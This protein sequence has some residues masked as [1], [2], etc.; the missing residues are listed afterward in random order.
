MLWLMAVPKSPYC[1]TLQDQPVRTSL[2]RGS[3]TSPASFTASSETSCIRTISNMT[4]AHN[5]ASYFCLC[6]RFSCLFWSVFDAGDTA[7][8]LSGIRVDFPRLHQRRVSRETNALAQALFMCCESHI[9]LCIDALTV[10]G[11]VTWLLYL[12]FH[13]NW[14]L[15]VTVT[16]VILF[17]LF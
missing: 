10:A 15:T 8:V 6:C 3:D 5:V 11:W 2:P 16:S 9:L 7:V 4:E 14:F 1:S 13:T 12:H 17:Y